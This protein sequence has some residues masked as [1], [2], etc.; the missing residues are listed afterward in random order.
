ME[1]RGLIDREY[2]HTVIRKR[3]KDVHKGDCGKV[4]I[5][6]GSKEMAGAAVFASRA[7]IK[8]GSGLVKTCTNRK[9]FPVL[10]T[11]VPEAICMEWGNTKDDLM[12]YDCIAVGPGMGVDRRSKNILR[13]ILKHF[14][15]TVVI[16]ADGLNTVA[17]HAELQQLVRETKASVIMTP[18][19]GE[20]KRLLGN[21][22]IADLTRIEIASFLRK[23]YG[24]IIIVK[25]TGTLVAVSDEDAYINT[26]G[27]PGMA[28]AGSGDVLTGIITSLAGQGLAPFDAA[29]AGVF[30]HGLSGDLAADKLGEYG[31]VA[32]DIADYVPFALKEL[33]E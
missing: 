7:A 9:I 20:A 12:Q 3:P 31:L 28:T 23:K 10:Q 13:M 24:C 16:D 2:V 30:V 27:N 1:I 18:H 33:T 15:K 6:A 26:T 21:A 14:D 29:R 22:D 32:S 5:L 25:G 8:C 11:S 4:L 17:R 19:I